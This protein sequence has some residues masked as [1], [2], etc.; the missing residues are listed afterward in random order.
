VTP[1]PRIRLCC[2]PYA[3][4]GAAVFREWNRVLAP[5]IDVC[6]VRLPGRENRW[7]EP[8]FSYLPALVEHLAVDLH[9]FSSIPVA[10]FGHSMG[11]LIAFELARQLRRIG[12]LAPR[13]LLV[14]GA[15]APQRPDPSSPIHHLPTP[16]FARE[17][18]ALAGTPDEVLRNP[19]LMMLLLPTLRADFALCETYV[20]VPEAP[21]DCSIVAYRG[22][23]DAHVNAGDVA[24]WRYQTSRTFAVRVLPG[25]H[26]FLHTARAALL[27]AVRDDVLAT[28]DRSATRDGRATNPAA[29]PAAKP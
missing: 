29:N 2:F 6:A 25:G 18:R 7:M 4:G 5:N 23:E 3:G 28:L 17:L 8:P 21:L 27:N 1:E 12:A 16:A 10:F 19:E 24:A 11:A 20:H 9:P 14:S 13:L 26:F 22:R 15:R